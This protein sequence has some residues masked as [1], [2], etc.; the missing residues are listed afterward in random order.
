MIVHFRLHFLIT[1]MVDFGFT[2]LLKEVLLEKERACG[3]Q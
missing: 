1:E 2:L 3:G